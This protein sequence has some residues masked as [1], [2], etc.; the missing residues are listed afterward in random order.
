[1]IG[2]LMLAIVTSRKGH[3]EE[4]NAICGFVKGFFMLPSVTESGI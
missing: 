1:M 3:V 4:G 2:A